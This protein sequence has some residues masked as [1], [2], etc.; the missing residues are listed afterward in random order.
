[1]KVY[2]T[3]FSEVSKPPFGVKKSS[4]WSRSLEWWHL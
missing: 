1:M 3:V 4:Y 2:S